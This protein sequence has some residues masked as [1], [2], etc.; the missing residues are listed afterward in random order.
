MKIKLYDDIHNIHIWIKYLSFFSTQYIGIKIIFALDLN[1]CI[2]GQTY[3]PW[4]GRGINVQ[5]FLL[6]FPFLILIPFYM[7]KLWK[8]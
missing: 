3:S 1:S 5:W 8:M 4:S 6:L 7:G 2:F